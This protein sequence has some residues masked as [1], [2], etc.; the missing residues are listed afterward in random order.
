MASEARHA[1]ALSLALA[2]GLAIGPSTARADNGSKRSDAPREDTPRFDEKGR[3]IEA[4]APGAAN[5]SALEGITLPEPQNHTQ[6]AYTEAA[7]AANVQGSVVL[8]VTIDEAG[9]VVLAKVESGLGHGLDESAL[10]AA[11]Q[12]LFSPARRHDGT[13]F[14]ATIRYRFEFTLELR[15]VEPGLANKP[16]AGTEGTSDGPAPLAK[17]SV[18]APAAI[19]I[20]V[21]DEVPPREVTRHSVEKRELERIPGT[22]GDALRSLQS[23]PGVARPPGLLGALLVRGSGPTDTQTF[24]DGTF[25]PIIYH[26]GGLTS[27]IPTELL[28][29]LDFY[30]GNFS[31][32]YGRAMGGIVDAG[33][34]APRADGLHGMAQVDLIDTRA[35]L[36]GPVPET[37]GDFTFAVAGRRSY[38]DAWL[39]P[40]LE[41]AG[42]GVTQAPVYY[43]YQLVIDGRPKRGHHMRTS[44]Y[45]SDDRL[46]L[47]LNDPTPNEPALSGDVGLSTSF[48]RLAF[49]YDLDLD[50]DARLESLVSLGRERVE[51]SLSQFFFRARV[52]SLFARSEYQKRLS[53]SA[54]MNV[55]I[56]LFSTA[57]DVALR[58]PAPPRP[59]QPPNQPFSTRTVETTSERRFAVLPAA[60]CEFELTPTDRTR[61]VPGFR[62]DYFQLNDA[63]DVS[64]RLNA[65]YVVKNNFPRTTL[66]AG[67]GVFSQPPQ[68]PEILPP[69]GSRTISSN[70]AFHYSLGAEQELT[71]QLDVTLEGFAKQLDN[72]VVSHASI[73]GRVAFAN[74]ASG[75][76]VGGEL[77]LKY[78][79]DAR[80]FG[81][82]SYTL[83]RSARADGPDEPEHLVPWD[84]THILTALG[85]YRIGAGWEVGARVRLVSGS[86]VTPNV[87]DPTSDACDPNRIG[88]LFHGASG[89]YTP[90][91]SAEIFT[92]RMPLFH[93]LDLRV[94][95]SWQF[96]LWKLGAYLDIQ[97][98]YNQEN[99]E[100]IQY[101][102]NFTK[103]QFLTGLPIIPSLGVRG[104]F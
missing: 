40:V 17:A 50:G 103:R 24:V 87:C 99:V 41:A 4:S 12:L 49:S 31:A 68:F 100:A 13:P 88:A 19:D 5:A 98:A 1:F 10:A 47:L 75:Y 14:R 26:F 77:L 69:F 71:A 84:Q 76:A 60:Y 8:R 55:G 96:K 38:V 65:R 34:R 39:G 18:A 51:F 29:R 94:D 9:K 73:D 85:S 104:E 61:I 53:P 102:F 35:L 52:L 57:F 22:N 79:P 28:E 90:I 25:V 66:K 30:P 46:E 33:L 89:A 58:L 32:R 48:Q 54:K 36:E 91:P 16:L 6:P 27:V 93:E 82:V 56:D 37:G 97:N 7:Q 2:V 42:A 63:L 3:P 11:R 64:P 43:D 62:V 83:S 44:F 78:K 95:K 23:L 21:T 59:G 72:L 45:G 70:R 92:E 101:N 74:D 86:L 20:F 80:F 67:T 15:E 81:W